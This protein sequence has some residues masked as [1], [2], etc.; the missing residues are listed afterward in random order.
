MNYV[1]KPLRYLILF[2]TLLIALVSQAQQL[3]SVLTNACN[4]G[5]SEGENEWLI[6]H[7]SGSAFTLK[8]NAPDVLYG[9]T[10]P[11]AT[12]YTD[13]ISPTGNPGYVNA[14]N[15]YLN[16]TCDFVFH[17]AVYGDS[18][19]TNRYLLVQ[20][21]TPTDTPDFSAWCG[22]GLD[23]VFVV[24]SEDPSWKTSGNFVNA[25]SSNRYFQVV[26][27]Q[28]TQN[29]YYVNGWTS[30]SDGN[31]V[32]WIDTGA[33]NAYINYP[34]CDPTNAV[35]LPVELI[36]LRIESDH[37]QPVLAWETASEWNNAGFSIEQ[38]VDQSTWMQIDFVLGAGTTMHTQH[39]RKPLPKTRSSCW[40]RLIQT[41]YD[42]T[43]T[44]SAPLA[45]EPPNNWIEV[46]NRSDEIV[47]ESEYP[48]SVQLITT[49]GKEL[50]PD[51]RISDN[52]QHLRTQNLEN[53]LY[54]LLIQTDRHATTY[55]IQIMH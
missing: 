5:G 19:G 32:T 22:E 40:Y 34:N 4:G 6:L 33:A 21:H 23:T 16:G 54:Y 31:V 24:F 17:N 2:L 46:M 42:G 36:S 13:S 28:D 51:I 7:H 27:N 41:D 45:W 14:L 3:R 30:N 55:P 50:H 43:Q 12:S 18:I 52:H 15:V 10:Y 35:A 47:L 9:S 37:N 53:G 38:T 1:L 29:Y 49:D 11:A 8:S 26:M 20:Y 39:Y 48:M 25:P 44:A